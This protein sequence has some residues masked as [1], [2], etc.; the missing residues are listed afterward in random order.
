MNNSKK[1]VKSKGIV[2]FANNTSQVD[3]VKIAE[4]TLK[5]AS[6]ILKL[7]YTII[8]EVDANTENIRYDID[9]GEF[10]PW[11]NNNRY[12]VYE[13][14]PYNETLVIDADYLVLD[15]NLLKIFSQPWD[16]LLQRNNTALTQAVPTVMGP[17]SLPFVW[18]TVLAFRK[19][20]RSKL[21]FDLVGRVQNN[22][23][24]YRLLF[25][26]QE[27]NYRND[28]AFAIADILLNGYTTS[29]ISIPGTMITV[30][31]VINSIQ[32]E[33]NRLV[34]KDSNRA[35]VVPRTNLHI[36]SKAY[37]QSDNFAQLVEQLVNEP[38]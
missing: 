28:Y 6:H 14:S 36:M 7:P 18:G 4:Q 12:Q 35:Y 23:G 15:Q 1:S 32:I 5:I 22:Y 21:F 11:R 3:Y 34:I 19:T 17:N 20:P 33:D 31:Q 30:D 37:L 24:Y 13:Q 10:I 2:A 26:M 29:T 16:Y 25:N 38:A 27:R 8:S 9:T